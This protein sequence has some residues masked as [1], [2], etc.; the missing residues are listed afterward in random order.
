[1]ERADKLAFARVAELTEGG[2]SR[3]VT[4][5]YPMAD[6][7]LTV[8]GD[9]QFRFMLIQLPEDFSSTAA[10]SPTGDKPDKPNKGKEKGQ[11][12]QAPRAWHWC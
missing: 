10:E 1:M 12:Q 3:D 7:L 11:R 6:A 2:L 9:A 8:I 4:G 5:R